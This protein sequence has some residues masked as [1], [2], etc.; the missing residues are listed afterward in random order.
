M[1]VALATIDG[2]TR[3]EAEHNYI[4]ALAEYITY[5]FAIDHM[6]L[7]LI[8]RPDPDVYLWAKGLVPKPEAVKAVVGFQVREH[9][10]AHPPVI[11]TIELVSA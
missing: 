11:R 3:Q 1:T 4:K 2:I 8:S 9:F 5:I 7:D 10:A 6:V